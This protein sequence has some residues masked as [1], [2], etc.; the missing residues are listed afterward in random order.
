[1]SNTCQETKLW[2]SAPLD[3]QE[4]REHADNLVRQSTP[5][6]QVDTSLEDRKP[7]ITPHLGEQ[8]H[9]TEEHF[10]NG[11]DDEE[12]VT[13]DQKAENRPGPSNRSNLHTSFVSANRNV[14]DSEVVATTNQ[15]VTPPRTENRRPPDGLSRRHKCGVCG[16]KFKAKHHLK[17][18]FRIHSGEK[19]FQCSNCGKRFSHSGSYSSHKAANRCIVV[20][21]NVRKNPP[22]ASSSDI[23]E[24]FCKACDEKISSHA[25][26]MSHA[27]KCPKKAKN[28]QLP[29]ITEV[30]LKKHQQPGSN[31]ESTSSPTP[32]DGQQRNTA[33]ADINRETPPKQDE[34][35]IHPRDDEFP[36]SESEI[37]EKSIPESVDMQSDQFPPSQ[38]LNT[39]T[40]VADTS[41]TSCSQS[42]CS[43]DFDFG[44]PAGINMDHNTTHVLRGQSSSNQFELQLNLASW[45]D[46]YIRMDQFTTLMRTILLNSFVNPFW[47]LDLTPQQAITQ[48]L[49][50]GSEGALDGSATDLPTSCAQSIEPIDLSGG[51]RKI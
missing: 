5:P 18:H 32:S 40:A 2:F 23:Y 19:P 35:Q 42:S 31:S 47:A 43:A 28:L 34:C 21:L 16:K 45:I 25:E 9:N 38:T 12:N 13:S 17:E 4:T 24:Q 6:Q 44:Y 26:Y 49:S 50:S 51:K 10:E 30:C 7:E 11:T 1:M 33:E 14:N 29:K 3:T 8:Q 46:S 36:D 37:Y 39:S 41:A 48:Q 15:P 22:T 27:I 20:D